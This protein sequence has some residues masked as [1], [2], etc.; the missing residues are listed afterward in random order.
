VQLCYIDDFARLCLAACERPA[1]RGQAFI[2]TYRDPIEV[3]DLV[4][5]S[6]RAVGAWIPPVGPPRWLLALAAR[7][8]EAADAAGLFRGEPPLTRDKLDT[9]SVD[10][11]YRIAKMRALLGDEPQVGYDEGIQRTAQA[12]ALAR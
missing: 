5:R 9:I 2:L 12:L 8:F 4:A 3:G 10:R 1:A 7:V 6:A 11:A